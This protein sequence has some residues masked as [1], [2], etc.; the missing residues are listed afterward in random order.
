[1]ITCAAWADV[2]GDDRNELIVAGEW[3]TPKIFQYRNGSFEET[4]NTGLQAL[5]GWWQSLAVADLNGD[6]K[7]D[8]VLGNIGENFY[9]RPTE[10]APRKTLAE[11]LRWQR[12]DGCIFDA[13]HRW[14]RHA[15]FFKA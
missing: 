2:S 10:E 15:H 14:Q 5:S 4:A 3:M 12:C 13:N 7:Q 8:I 1:M 6:G 11:R 9:F